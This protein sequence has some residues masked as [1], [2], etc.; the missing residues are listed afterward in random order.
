MPIAA[1]QFA[2]DAAADLVLP[3]RVAVAVTVPGDN[4]RVYLT[5]FDK[6]GSPWSEA[7]VADFNANGKP[8]VVAASATGIDIDFFNGAGATALNASIIP[9]TRSVEHLATGDFDGDLVKDLA[10]VQ[11][12]SRFAPEDEL[13]IAFGSSAGPPA[14][15]VPVARLAGIQQIVTFLPGGD[16]IS[17]LTV[18]NDQSDEAGGSTSGLSLLI[19][20]GDRSLPCPIELTTFAADGSLET[21]TSMAA[22]VGSFT[23]QG[24]RDLMA[25]GF[26]GDFPQQTWDDFGMFLLPDV[27]SRRSPPQSLGRHLDLAIR[28]IVQRNAVFEL[29]IRF[30]NG[31]LDGD[32]LDDLVIMAPDSS[33]QRCIV[34]SASVASATS[35]LRL[36]QPVTLDEPCVVNNQLALADVDR[37]SALDVV[38]LI[39]ESRKLMV[40]WGDGAGGLRIDQSSLVSRD[41]D[42]PVAFTLFRSTATAPP[43]LAYVTERGVW[44]TRFVTSDRRFDETR[45][46][47]ELDQGTGI[48]A[49]DVNGDGV[50]DLVVADSGNVRILR[51]EL[52]E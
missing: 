40:L 15:P 41:T 28:P 33:T 6:L 29:P 4:Q 34:D 18:V 49:A 30:A 10:F 31:D 47:T 39:G 36:R 23:Q 12:G 11:V 38:M 9:T 42:A 25:L 35:E 52:V 24:R 13:S 22:T 45:L 51:A 14:P 20:S 3:S 37:D 2:G 8:D 43:G 17:S 16:T 32:G 26:Y 48:T 21:T 50:V 19:G 27:A 7:L 44:L 46:P 5:L 1:G